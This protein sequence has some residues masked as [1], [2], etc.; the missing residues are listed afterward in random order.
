MTKLLNARSQKEVRGAKKTILHHESWGYGWTNTSVNCL[1]SPLLTDV[2][3]FPCSPI[4]NTRIRCAKNEYFLR[5][6]Q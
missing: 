3:G 2:L 5:R 6:T 1:E 4:L